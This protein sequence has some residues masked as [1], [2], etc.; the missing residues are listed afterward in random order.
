MCNV[1]H[2][3]CHMSH[4]TCH[5]SHTLPG[6]LDGKDNRKMTDNRTINIATNRLNLP[7]GRF[8]EDIFFPSLLHTIMIRAGDEDG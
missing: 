6:E 8:S 7:R 5:V 4:V 2:V 1:S 3:M